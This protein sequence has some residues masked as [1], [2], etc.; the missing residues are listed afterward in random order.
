MK[1][2]ITL[3]LSCSIVLSI[4]S[5]AQE[6]LHLTLSEAKGYALRHNR[7][8]KSSE[9]AVQKAEAAKWQAIASML[10]HVDAKLGYTNFLGYS[11][12]LNLG[13]S[14]G[15]D[16]AANLPFNGDPLH[17]QMVGVAAETIG[18]LMGSGGATEIAMNPYG[19]L[20]LQATMV[21]TGMQVV[22]VQ[23][24]NLVID[25]SK[26]NLQLND[27][28]VKANVTTA[29]LS[30]LVA[31]QSKKL[32]ES[33]KENVQKLYE[34]TKK[35]Y[36]VGVA[37][38]T[39][40]DQLGVQ[41]GL[42]ANE[43]K[44]TERNIE[45]AYNALRLILGVNSAT[46]LALS[47]NIDNFLANNDAY[48]TAAA[49]FD[50]SKNYTVQLLNQNVKI[51]EKQV[52]LKTWEHTPTLVLFYQHS[53]K[54]YFGKAEGFN[55]TPPNT[56][57]ATVNIPIFSSGERYSKLTQAKI[58]L[59]SAQ[60]TRDDAVEGLRVQ[61][62]QLRFL[63]NSAIETY[64]LQKKN[65]EVSTRIFEKTVQKYQLGTVSSTELTTINNNLIAAQG[66]YIGALMELLTA[67]VNL[68]RLLQE[69]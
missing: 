41:V 19:D 34:T 39:A 37:E 61:E 54:T 51:S 46:E 1:R 45:L 55:M 22:G 59:K 6:K 11:A 23:L 28:N 4:N 42:I 32:L 33:S 47:D 68:Q 27:L 12:A 14:G 13:G 8:L 31:E 53:E 21:F 16:G 63:L 44:K 65:V 62:R 38:Q 60:L 29:Y 9:L 58:D 15:G 18:A 7:T 30:V 67:Q 66:S 3:L 48:A 43:V 49:E 56:I 52:A 24:S 5:F 2:K 57:G 64:E 35:M 25:M 17:D 69:L 10:P 40:V 26:K 50:M 36:E 20:A